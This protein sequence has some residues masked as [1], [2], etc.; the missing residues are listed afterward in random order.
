MAFVLGLATSR[1]RGSAFVIVSFAMLELLGLV[2]RNWSSV[3]GGSQ[4][5]LMPLPTWDVRRYA[6]PFYYALFALV[7]L[8]VA[9]SVW[10]RRSKFGLGLFAIRDDEEQGGR[11]RRR[12]ARCTRAWHSSPAPCSSASPVRVYGYYLS[13]LTVSA[14]FDIVLSMQVVLAVLLGGK[15]T[16][17]G[18]L[19]GAAIVVPLTEYTNTTIGGADAGAIRLVLFGGL[20]LAVVL[21]LPRGIIADVDRPA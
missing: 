11:H 3:T 9:M 14:M 19:L 7:L 2:V 13:F 1:T 4:G 5:F 16:M 6:W 17:W 20:L 18:P 15:G 8:S 10:I 12:H 21:L